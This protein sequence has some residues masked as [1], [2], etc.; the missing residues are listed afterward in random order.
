MPFLN[1]YTC[2]RTRRIKVQWRARLTGKQ[3]TLV[4]EL[5]PKKKRHLLQQ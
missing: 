4:F 2:A 3:L 5:F 1:V